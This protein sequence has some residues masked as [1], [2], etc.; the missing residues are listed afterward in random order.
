MPES[1]KTSMK[2]TTST[3]CR[4]LQCLPDISSAGSIKNKGL[5]THLEPPLIP[6][7]PPPN[8]TLW[9]VVFN[10]IH[11]LQ[12]TN[13]NRFRSSKE[14]GMATS[15]TGLF[16]GDRHQSI[17]E[18]LRALRQGMVTHAINLIC[19]WT[20]AILHVFYTSMTIWFLYP[21]VDILIFSNRFFLM[22]IYLLFS[23]LE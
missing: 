2:P 15:L 21:H 1:Y 14:N 9:V 17:V 7:P 23:Q 3:C 19:H 22:H 4:G 11:T 5:F 12:P 13:K 18:F 16:P 10:N 6:P 8:K 20:R